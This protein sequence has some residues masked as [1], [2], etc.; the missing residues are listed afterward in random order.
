[1]NRC[2]TKSLPLSRA[3][4]SWANRHI[5]E[6]YNAQRWGK[7]IRWAQRRAKGTSYSL[8]EKLRWGTWWKW[9]LNWVLT[10]FPGRT[11]AEEV[12]K[13]ERNVCTVDRTSRS[14]WVGNIRSLL[15]LKCEGEREQQAIKLQGYTVLQTWRG[16]S[17]MVYSLDLIL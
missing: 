3:C 4:S 12:D 2:K 10:V 8:K 13:G 9:S 6:H 7:D 5:V 1:M 16:L 17:V 11:T 15:T 14:I